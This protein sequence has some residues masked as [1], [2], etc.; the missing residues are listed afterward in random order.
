M[1][2][3][4]FFRTCWWGK[5]CTIHGKRKTYLSL[6]L[7][8]ILPRVASYK[9]KLKTKISSHS[10]FNR[11]TIFLKSVCIMGSQSYQGLGSS[12]THVFPVSG[13]E[14]TTCYLMYACIYSDRWDDIG[15]YIT[16]VVVLASFILLQ[17]NCIKGREKTDK[18]MKSIKHALHY[19]CCGPCY[20]L[21]VRYCIRP[22]I[23]T[24]FVA[25]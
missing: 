15:S 4:E 23:M 25:H 19:M 9:K 11:L 13:R 24:N 6:L 2:V 8:P 14:G 5:Q 7:P 16:C 1:N 21:V 22:S 10:R 17:L 18:E 20:L 12:Y 3:I